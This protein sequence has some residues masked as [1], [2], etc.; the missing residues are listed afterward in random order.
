MRFTFKLMDFEESR[1]PSIMW[2]VGFQFIE[3]INSSKCW[4]CPSMRNSPNQLPLGSIC[5]A[6]SS[7]LINGL[8]L[9]PNCSSFLSPEADKLSYQFLD[10]P[11]LHNH[12][13]SQ[14]LS[15]LV[16]F[17]SLYPYTSYLFCF[18]REPQLV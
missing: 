1:L 2:S 8:P 16:F 5:K 6:G 4:P 10:S 7:W 18:S 11:S 15:S 3:N 9:D 14:F 12:H 13:V 17:L